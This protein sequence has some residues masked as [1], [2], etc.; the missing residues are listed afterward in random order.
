MSGTDG[1]SGGGMYNGGPS[2]DDCSAVRID[3]PVAAPEPTFT[4]IVGIKL[5]VVISS[6]SP[7]TISLHNHGARV[8]S[9]HPYPALV[10]CLNAGVSFEAE[11]RN[12]T[13]GDIRVRVEPLP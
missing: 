11:I 2:G 5:D 7:V 1:P 4:F 8:G 3:D 12:V 13:G 6:H 9:L 10:R